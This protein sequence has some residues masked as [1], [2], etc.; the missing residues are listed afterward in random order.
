MANMPGMKALSWK[1][2]AMPFAK[3]WRVATPSRKMRVRLCDSGV[4]MQVPA[5]RWARSSCSGPISQNCSGAVR[6]ITRPLP[7]I[8]VSAR[9]GRGPVTAAIAASISAE[10]PA[11]CV[12]EKPRTSPSEIAALETGLKLAKADRRSSI[13]ALSFGID[14]MRRDDS[15]PHLLVLQREG[16]D[17]FFAYMLQPALIEAE[18]NHLL[19]LG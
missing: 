15:G 16:A 6:K 17:D 14:E 19:Q 4:T 3:T 18:C 7:V 2:R 12:S 9:G 8:A 1:S 10:K 13:E 11:A 5:R